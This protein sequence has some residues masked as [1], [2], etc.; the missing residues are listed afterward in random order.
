MT[1]FS[2][3]VYN[4]I[5]FPHYGYYLNGIAVIAITLND[6]YEFVH[7]VVLEDVF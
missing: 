4:D 2:L 6:R 7:T 3:Q 5:Y 1:T